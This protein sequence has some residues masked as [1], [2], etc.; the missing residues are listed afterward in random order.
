MSEERRSQL[1]EIAEKYP[2]HRSVTS[3]TVIKI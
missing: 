2:I 1:L 3:E